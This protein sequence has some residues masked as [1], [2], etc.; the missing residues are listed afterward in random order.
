MNETLRIRNPKY[1]PD[2]FLFRARKKEI[3][4]FQ[5]FRRILYER[6]DQPGK[7]KGAKGNNVSTFFS[8]RQRIIASKI[9]RFSQQELSPAP[10][11]VKTSEL[12]PHHLQKIREATTRL[13]SNTKELTLTRVQKEFRLEWNP[14]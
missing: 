10:R 6:N 12:Q 14:G 7:R 8:S 9:P 5:I 13:R 2:Y 11:M 4:Y 1:M 3:R